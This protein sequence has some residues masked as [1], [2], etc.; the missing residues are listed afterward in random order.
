[1]VNLDRPEFFN[2]VPAVF[3]RDDCIILRVQDYAEVLADRANLGPP[4]IRFRLPLRMFGMRHPDIRLP[5]GPIA[6]QGKALAET[7]IRSVFMALAFRMPY[8]RHMTCFPEFRT[9]QWE[10]GGCLN[11][12]MLIGERFRA[13]PVAGLA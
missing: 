13:W 1:M 4:G 9:N 6:L 5:L 7:K 3:G 12:L 8:C 11:H 10:A 2:G